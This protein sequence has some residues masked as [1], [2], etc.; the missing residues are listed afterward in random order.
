MVGIGVELV[1]DLLHFVRTTTQFLNNTDIKTY[2]SEWVNVY[3]SCKDF[4][5]WIEAI[6]TYY[7]Y[8]FITYSILCDIFSL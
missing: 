6:N 2:S 3:S 1:D 5:I 4:M 7:K 8:S